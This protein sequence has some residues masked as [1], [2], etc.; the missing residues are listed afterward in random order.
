MD[1]SFF[2]FP[3][4]SLIAIMMIIQDA[5]HGQHDNIGRS[6]FDSYCIFRPEILVINVSTLKQF[7]MLNNFPPIISFHES[8][9]TYRYK[10][11]LQY[12][13]QTITLIYKEFFLHFLSLIRRKSK[14]HKSN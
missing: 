8:Q 5:N 2:G 6:F 9:P 13:K 7:F 11:Y 10:I 3:K 12:K 14:I 1:L 4:I